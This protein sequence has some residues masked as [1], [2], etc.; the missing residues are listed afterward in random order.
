MELLSPR[1]QELRIDAE[2]ASTEEEIL[3]EEVIIADE[4]DF[5]EISSGERDELLSI[6]HHERS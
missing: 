3:A 2:R 6:L 1:S 4:C 5:G